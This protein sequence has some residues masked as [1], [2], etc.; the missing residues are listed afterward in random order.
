MMQMNF[1]EKNTQPVQVAL[2]EPENN[3]QNNRNISIFFFPREIEI[4]LPRDTNLTEKSVFEKK[5]NIFVSQAANITN[6][7][8][9]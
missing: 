4:I 3:T 1:V 7:P 2:E 8:S 6:C 5:I 9:G